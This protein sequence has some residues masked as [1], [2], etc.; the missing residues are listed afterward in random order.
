LANVEIIEGKFLFRNKSIYINE[1]TRLIANVP[2]EKRSDVSLA[3]HL[4]NDAH[5]KKF[6]TAV[7][8]SNDSDLADA[9]RIVT[10]ELK[11]KVGLISP[12]PTF[13]KDIAKYASFKIHA[14]EGAIADSQFPAAIFDAHGKLTKP[15]GW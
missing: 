6:E 2:E 8:I 15:P 1:D 11:L 12:Y 5:L 7:V 3:A 14:R 4:V 9:I 13:H 10:E